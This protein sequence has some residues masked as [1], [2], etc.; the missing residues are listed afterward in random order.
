M[1]QLQLQPR[2]QLLLTLIPQG[3]RLVDVG[4]DHGYLP[5]ALLQQ[6]RIQS[7]IATDIGEEPLQHARRTAAEY[8]ITNLDFRLCD[9]LQGVSPD[10]V[11]TIVIA[12]M[13]GETIISI[14]TASPWTRAGKILLLQ[15]MTKVELLRSWLAENGY[16]FRQERL[17]WDKGILYPISIVSGGET[18]PLTAIEQYAGVA[19]DDDP[20][21][22]DY[23]TSQMSRLQKA[24]EGLN[25]A[26]DCCSHGRACE[27]EAIRKALEEK[28][29][30]RC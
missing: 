10:E 5:V 29:D 19:M 27:F 4:T 30:K 15:P 12:G 17:V 23:L 22:A 11:D 7:A 25:R 14:L 18:R 21:Y 24:I 6:G 8:E 1:K 26:N 20:L 28:R 2:L 13:G 3:A 16:A 9:G